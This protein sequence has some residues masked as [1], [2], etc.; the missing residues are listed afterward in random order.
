MFRWDD[1]L[2]VGLGVLHL[3]YDVL[4]TLTPFQFLQLFRG[5]EDRERHDAIK[6]A[7]LLATLHNVNR[8]D[9]SQE[10][11]GIKDILPWYPDYIKGKGVSQRGYYAE[12]TG[13][14]EPQ[15]LAIDLDPEELLLQTTHSLLE[16]WGHDPNTTPQDSPEWEEAARVARQCCGV[17]LY[18]EGG[19]VVGQ[20]VM[21]YK[22]DKSVWGEAGKPPWEVEDERIRGE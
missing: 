15:P 22:V 6:R 12:P 19:M 7:E 2:T 10:I 8:M 5:W 14:F 11:V 16:Q 1:I 4:F 18:K 13:Q 17:D 9:E 21:I 20:G 3:S